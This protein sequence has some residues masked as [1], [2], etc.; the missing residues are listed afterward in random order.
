MKTDVQNL[1]MFFGGRWEP[2]ANGST[3][4][5][6]DPYRAEVWAEVPEATPEDVRRAIAAARSA[7][8]QGPWPRLSGRDRARSL[9][10][11]ATLIE[12]SAEVLIDAEVRDNGKVVREVRGQ[13][14]SLP[15]YYEYFAGMADK[16][17]GRVLPT[18]RPSQQVF[19]F[20]EPIGVVAAIAAWNSPLL[21]ATYKLA[22]ALAAGCTVVLKPS[23][24]TPVSAL[25]FA[26]LCEEA[27]FPPGVLNVVTGGPEVGRTLVADPRIDKV[28]FTGSTRTGISVAESAAAHLAPVSLELGGKSPNIVFADADIEAA[29]NG[30][31]AGIFAA[32]G[33]TC[34][35]GSRLL[36]QREIHDALIERIVDR[37]R[38]I[39][40]GD[41]KATETEMGPLAFSGHRDYVLARIEAAADEGA[42]VAL[43][44][45]APTDLGPGFFVEPTVLVGVNNTM[46][47]ARD[48]IFGPVLAAIPF[49]DDD[50]AVAIANDS[51]HGLAAGVWTRDV[52][53][54]HR[55][56]PRL[57]VGTV[58]V[59]CYRLIS[60]DIPFG[61]RKLSGYGRENGPAGIREYLVSKY[62]WIETSGATRDP[63]VLG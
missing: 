16:L 3:H 5:S 39:R 2:A 12:Q 14:A 36:V 62:A 9:H 4:G 32:A 27:D 63:F 49:G 1:E 45:G 38:T 6:I 58:W 20:H 35:A 44:G 46:T 22:P 24:H 56:I 8:D 52:G 41:P 17:E 57:Q 23:E 51:P 31:I 18:F 33:Q 60:Y 54:A 48:E 40:L 19:E 42:T 29:A 53:R 21:I 10:R 7:F 15:E 59:N 47:V 11:L 50:E 43:G 61:G 13:I 28:A 25:H 30:V 34:V 55:L 26:R 37:A